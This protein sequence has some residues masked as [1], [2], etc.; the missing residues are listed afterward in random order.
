VPSGADL[1]SGRDDPGPAEHERA[2]VR[3]LLAAY[4][5]EH[6][7]PNCAA[8]DGSLK[9]SRSALLAHF[10]DLHP[11]EI[12]PR[13]VREF[14]RKRK[15]GEI[16]GRSKA[17]VARGVQN[18]TIRRDLTLLVAALNH[19]VAQHRMKASEVPHIDLP[20]ENGPRVRWLTDAELARLFAA[21]AEISAEKGR[22]SRIERWLHI[23]Y[24]AARRKAAVEGLA[25]DR[26]DFELNTADFDVPGRRRTK[27][28]RGVAYLHPRLRTVLE[29]ARVEREAG[30][31]GQPSPW[32]LDHPGDIRA[33]FRVLRSRAGLGPDVTIHTLKHS[34]ITHMLRR[35][36][37][38]WDVAGATETSPE[39]IRKVYGNHVPEAMKAA[40]T[41]LA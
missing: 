30:D 16:G 7:E 40:L 23:A 31:N 26:I 18:P 5:S 2:T 13:D 17:G 10:A 41:A 1:H 14:V 12:A 37:S 22:V 11:A 8:K 35:G 3:G 15:A 32:V 6:V 36:V 4:W 21:A 20:P 24:Y 9:S 28:R 38:I 25:W 33:A 34:S 39:T 29:R 27:K 19:S